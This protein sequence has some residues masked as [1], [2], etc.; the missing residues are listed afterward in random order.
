MMVTILG[1][2][3][4]LGG[5][6]V[7]SLVP[8]RMFP[9]CLTSPLDLVPDPEDCHIFYQCDLN[10]QPMSCGDMMFNSY[11]QVCDWPS[12]V[13]QVRP[14]CRE[15]EQLRFSTQDYF[16]HR[17]RTLRM[18]RL[19]GDGDKFSQKRLRAPQDV[20]L[21]RRKDFGNREY[22]G[23]EEDNRIEPDNED[24]YSDYQYEDYG[25]DVD[26][27]EYEEQGRDYEEEELDYACHYGQRENDA[28]E[29][30]SDNK[31]LV[32]I[33]R[34]V[35]YQI[36]KKISE[37]VEKSI[38][39]VQDLADPQFHQGQAVSEPQDHHVQDLADPQEHHVQA[40]S[41]PADT[42]RLHHGYP[43]PRPSPT[44]VEDTREYKP[45]WT[46]TRERPQQTPLKMRMKKNKKYQ[47][48]NCDGR[49]CQK[50]THRV[51]RK[52]KKRLIEEKREALE[53]RRNDLNK[54]EEVD[55]VRRFDNGED[56]RALT[57]KEAYDRAV[58]KVEK[59]EA[60]DGKDVEGNLLSQIL[61]RDF[62]EYS[63]HNYV[64]SD[65]LRQ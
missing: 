59:V 39:E 26:S 15:L 3:T 22:F 60:E 21:G 35:I 34:R 32:D 25:E 63:P 18:L 7:L 61:N 42:T 44:V 30:I 24:N 56:D 65:I 58:W 37:A 20:G 33:D 23:G 43:S 14:E 41:D 27:G 16:P 51:L 11:R 10:P 50:K 6:S 49:N 13:V 1:M 36:E 40:V 47:E 31:G 54:K 5:S 4:L 29:K 8:T 9:T 2:V 64:S 17:Q 38:N 12:T 62:G 55:E 52:I 46:V 19:F 45:V 57:L 28:T 48:D 53:E